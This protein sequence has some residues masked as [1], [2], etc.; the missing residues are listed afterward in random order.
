[1][2]EEIKNFFASRNMDSLVKKESTSVGSGS[3]TTTSIKTGSTISF[4]WDGGKAG[5]GIEITE[6]GMCV[7]LKEQSY[8]F[9]TVIS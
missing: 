2:Y 3:G 6:M 9:R 8:V 7:F 4:K 5:A 1:M